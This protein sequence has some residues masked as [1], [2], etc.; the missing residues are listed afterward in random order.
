[1]SEE[2][3]EEITAILE[4]L[5]GCLIKNGVS[6]ATSGKELCFFDTATY[7]DTR[8]FTGVKVNIEELVK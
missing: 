7:I 4:L 2:T 5:K 1:M 8:I 6:M 3:K